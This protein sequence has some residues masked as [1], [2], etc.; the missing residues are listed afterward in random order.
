MFTY[1]GRIIEFFDHGY[2]FDSYV[3]GMLVHCWLRCDHGCI[4]VWFVSR[5]VPGTSDNTL[6]Q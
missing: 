2:D 1:K 4:K 3:G 5:G 6:D